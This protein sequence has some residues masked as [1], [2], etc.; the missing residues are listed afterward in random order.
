MYKKLTVIALF[1]FAL[2][3]SAQWQNPLIGVW[4][5]TEIAVPNEPKITTPQPGLYIFTPKYYSIVRI[6]SG[7]PGPAFA[8]RA[9]AKD[10]DIIATFD[11][12]VAQSGTYTVSGSTIR[13][14]PLVAKMPYVMTGPEAQYEFSRSGT[15]LVLTDKPAD[16]SAGTVVR[17][18]RVE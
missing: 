16:G 10:A 15:T 8:S 2:A 18:T 4:K 14:R 17:L 5:V 7:K 13:R 9:E 11:A 6:E 1:V 3:V 12:L